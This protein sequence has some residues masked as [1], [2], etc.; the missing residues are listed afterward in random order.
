MTKSESKNVNI[1]DADLCG[2]VSYFIDSMICKK[3][4]FQEDIEDI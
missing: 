1:A 2:S 3:M 4:E